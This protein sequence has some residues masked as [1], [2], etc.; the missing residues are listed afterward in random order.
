MVQDAPRFSGPKSSHLVF[1]FAD[2]V[3]ITEPRV[4]HHHHT[5][6]QQL[7]ICI[8]PEQSM[9]ISWPDAEDR[10]TGNHVLCGFVLSTGHGR[11]NKAAVIPEPVTHQTPTT[12]TVICLYDKQIRTQGC[13]E[14]L[15]TTPAENSFMAKLGTVSTC[16]ARA[17]VGYNK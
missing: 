4:H 5:G 14:L 7:V 3:L 10:S 11:D 1:T 15:L 17:Q 6:S 9:T 12:Q 8:T 13:S 2:D 16:Y